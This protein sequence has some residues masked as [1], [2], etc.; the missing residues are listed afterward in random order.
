M[1][2]SQHSCLCIQSLLRMQDQDYIFYQHL[3]Y[4]M[5][6]TEYAVSYLQAESVCSISKMAVC[7]YH[8][9]K[10][11]LTRSR[12]R[13]PLTKSLT[14]DLQY[15]WYRSSLFSC[16]GISLIGSAAGLLVLSRD[17]VGPCLCKCQYLTSC[18]G[19]LVAFLQTCQDV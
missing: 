18:F 7:C 19:L 1:T 13:Y 5:D 15:Y 10:R 12:G 4:K 8:W 3:L 17:F 9:Y 16:H 14:L 2:F 6:L 11:T